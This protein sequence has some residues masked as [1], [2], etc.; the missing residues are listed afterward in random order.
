MKID[1]FNQPLKDDQINSIMKALQ[2]VSNDFSFLDTL[3]NII[4]SPIFYK[5]DKG[6]YKFCN[7][8]FCEYLG[9]ERN[10]IIDHTVYDIAPINLA[11]IYHQ[12]DLDLMQSQEN[13]VYESQV[14]Y[15][16]GT[17][18]DVVFYKNVHINDLNQ[19]I[20]LVG[21]MMD[22]TTQKNN[23]RLIQRQNI[24]KDVLLHINHSINQETDLTKFFN[25]LLHQ[26]ISAIP[27]AEYGTILEL[28][29]SEQLKTL[30]YYGYT[31]SDIESFSI[32]LES[33]FL[34]RHS[35]GNLKSPIIISNL[36]IYFEQGCPP[37]IRT[38]D[39]RRIQSTIAIPITLQDNKTIILS[40]D[41]PSI[42]AFTDL[43]YSVAEYI[44]L[45]IPIIYQIFSLNKR[46][47]ELS[48]YDSLT[49]LMNRG[50]FN[51]IFED[52]L[53]L[54]KRHNQLL[55]VIMFD[56][57]GLKIVNDNF[58]H[59]AG[60]AYLEHF[61]N[62]INTQ[63]R[64]S[65][66][67]ARIGGDEFLGIFSTTDPLTLKKK[68]TLLQT[69]YTELPIQFEDNIFFGRFSYGIATYPIDADTID[70]LLTVADIK[71]YQDKKNETNS[72]H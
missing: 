33:S 25:L 38:L 55:S 28:D 43:D 57:D 18:H 34:Y 5:N 10:A 20:G 2:L 21:L 52:R 50:Y 47:I 42:N 8:A 37:S 72:T 13:Q 29:A 11:N 14:R 62:F 41:S 63:F 22:I 66:T 40:L 71:M 30:V 70:G 6:I 64:S 9:L 32:P 1:N 65:D 60:D 46:T 12:A 56:L 31:P 53:M 58:G 27:A 19:T 35:G 44:Q 68:M 67:F 17:L 49:G 26:L 4:P 54:A 51:I 23:E 15:K 45:Q 7:N 69:L 3:F 24:I 59:A 16:D 39:G 48:R 61:A 36:S